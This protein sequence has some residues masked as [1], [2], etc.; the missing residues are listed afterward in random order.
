[1]FINTATAEEFNTI[2]VWVTNRIENDNKIKIKKAEDAI[3]NILLEL[4][5][6]GFNLV[7]KSIEEVNYFNMYYDKDENN[8]EMSLE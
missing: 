1:M 5:N 2:K 7:D 6:D 4:H 8:I 3:N